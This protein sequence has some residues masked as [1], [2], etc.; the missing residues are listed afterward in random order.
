MCVVGGR[1]V[2]GALAR[3]RWAVCPCSRSTRAEGGLAGQVHA[4]VGQ[5]RHDARGRHGGKARRVGHGK[6]LRTLGLGQRMTGRRSHG[7][8]PSI[9]AHE[10]VKGFP[11]LQGAQVDAGGLA[12]TLQPRACRMRGVDVSG[13]G[14]AI[15][16]VDHASSPLLKIA[17]TFFD[18][19]KRAAVSAS[20]RSLRSSSRSSS[21]MRFLSARVACGLARASSGSASAAAAAAPHRAG[22]GH[23]R[24]RRQAGAARRQRRNAQGDDGAGD[25]QLAGR[26]ALV[27]ATPCER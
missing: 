1:T 8:W 3:P 27:L 12:G 2:R 26:Q 14:L 22:R 20:A 17:A 6:H 19:T 25:A 23:C 18:S 7:M 24:A 4:L 21:L 16:E 9:A 10:A 11:A 15:F 13:Q 5:H